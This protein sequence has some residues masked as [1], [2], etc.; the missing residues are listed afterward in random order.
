MDVNMKMPDL[1]TTEGSDLGVGRWLVGVGQAVKRGQPLL[2][3]ETDKAVQ[4]VESIVS[5]ILKKIH[6]PA[7][8]KVAVGAIIAT[9]QVT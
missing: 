2:E 5:G 6:V 9:I 7:G 1:A 4:E 3:V 8:E